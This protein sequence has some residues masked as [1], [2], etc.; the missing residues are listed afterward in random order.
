ML[1]LFS[2]LNNC[3]YVGSCLLNN[4]G[5]AQMVE[6]ASFK[7]MVVG[8]N[9]TACTKNYKNERHRSFFS[10]K[11]DFF[12]YFIDFDIDLPSVKADSVFGGNQFELFGYVGNSLLNRLPV[13]KQIPA[14][15]GARYDY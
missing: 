11:T 7:R 4:A 6:Q 5:I 8:S 12:F 10:I 15:P 14:N 3:L 1:Y 2:W 9:P 13:S